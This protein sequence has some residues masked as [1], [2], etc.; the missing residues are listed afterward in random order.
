MADHHPEDTPEA[1][2]GMPE[3]PVVI[4]PLA[5]RQAQMFL[6]KTYAFIG[7]PQKIREAIESSALPEELKLGHFDD[8]EAF[9]AA[10]ERLAGIPPL[11][12]LGQKYL[13]LR[14]RPEVFATYLYN[15]QRQGRLP[16]WIIPLF[17]YPTLDPSFENKLKDR[18]I[19]MHR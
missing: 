12:E 15:L 14:L 13:D 2:A 3:V 8:L 4:N 7:N 16:R 17:N 1:L 19:A 10:V 5:Q 11:R 6:Q 9:M 18:I